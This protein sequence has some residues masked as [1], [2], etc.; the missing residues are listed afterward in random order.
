MKPLPR[1]QN[2]I[3]IFTFS[4]SCKQTRWN[5]AFW[6]THIFPHYIAT[7]VMALQT[8]HTHKRITLISNI[9]SKLHGHTVLNWGCLVAAGTPHAQGGGHAQGSGKLEGTLL[10]GIE[11]VFLRL[12]MHAFVLTIAV[13]C[14]ASLGISVTLFSLML[15]SICHMV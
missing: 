3:Q 1:S 10:I 6:R 9:L 11:D 14:V 4:R 2:N 8:M 13:V 5:L 12:T 15:T 7:F